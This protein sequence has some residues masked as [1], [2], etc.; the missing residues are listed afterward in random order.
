[1]PVAGLVYFAFRGSG[2]VWPHLAAYVLPH[3]LRTTLLLLL[4]VGVLTAGIGVG[5]AWLVSMCRFPGRRVF[6]WA[7]LLPLAVP[8]Y[9]V[10]YAYLDVLHP[11]GP[12]QTA[13]RALLGIERPR[14]LWF[15]EIR[16]LPGCI[17]LLSVVLYPYVYLP[18]RALFVMQSAAVLDVARTLGADRLRVF[19]RIALPLA[20]PAIVVGVSLALMETLNDIGASEFLGVR[21]L[22]VAIYTTWTVRMSVEGAAQIAL[23]MLAVVVALILFERWAR[24]RQ[25]FAASARGHY[26]PTQQALGPA[27]AAAAS[28]ACF[29]PVFFG[30]IVPTSYLVSSAIRRFQVSGLPQALPGWIANSLLFASMATLVTI[31]VGLLL[32]Y[33]VRLSRS[34]SAPVLVRL[35]SIGYAVPG[36]VLAVGLLVPLASF[37]NALD[38]FMRTAFGVSTG[39]LLTGSGGALVVAYVI[40]FLAISAGG[41]EAG[42]SKISPHL[43]MAARSLGSRPLRVLARVHLPLIGPAI[44]AAALLVFVDC[45]KEL[46]ATLLLQP[47]NFTTLATALYG[48][49][50]RGTYE[51]G[52]IAALAI[53]LVGLLPV[54]VLARVNAGFGMRARRSSSEARRAEVG[55][56]I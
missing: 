7:L 48:E 55:E 8:T 9:I 19:W 28:L 13:L 45:M 38:A 42:L 30:F 1:M 47:F 44:A 51:D 4:G 36:T 32:A 53:V 46:P 54:M 10:A 21:T 40:R 37:D 33:S 15:P 29:A 43:D 16:S 6:A 56:H 18:V 17:F 49:A 11:V 25:R 39:L 5:A 41:I 14:D 50:K 2:D 3:A 22:T 27:A 31:L 12:V 23:V 52:A 20:R 34:P 26:T 24:R 35:A